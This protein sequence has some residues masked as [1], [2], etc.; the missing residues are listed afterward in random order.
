MVKR[1]PGYYIAI[2]AVIVTCLIVL[3]CAV[4]LS[5]ESFKRIIEGNT[6]N[7]FDTTIQSMFTI[8]YWQN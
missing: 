8:E 5:I 2:I 6:V 3:T 7:P 1:S 4:L